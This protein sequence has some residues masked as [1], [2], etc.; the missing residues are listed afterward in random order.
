MI[1]QDKNK[2]KFANTDNVNKKI[3]PDV[4]RMIFY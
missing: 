1:F 4:S 3:I 2:Y